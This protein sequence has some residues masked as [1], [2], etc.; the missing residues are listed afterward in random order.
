M[1][2]WTACAAIGIVRDGDSALILS[3]PIALAA[4]G[5][6]LLR[7][8]V[9]PLADVVMLDGDEVIVRKN[10][11]EAHFSVRQIANVDTSSMTNPE[12]ITLTLR[13]SCELGREIAFIPASHFHLFSLH[14]IV[15]ELI[16]RS[17]GL[18]PNLGH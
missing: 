13:E 9:F 2:L 6:L 15:E 16:A 11:R 7:W 5:W 8:L 4:L 3:A 17:H 10:G 18:E 12:K 1:A 14:P